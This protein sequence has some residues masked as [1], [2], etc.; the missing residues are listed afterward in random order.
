[1]TSKAL[2][3]TPFKARLQILDTHNGIQRDF[4]AALKGEALAELAGDNATKLPGLTVP[5]KA[6]PAAG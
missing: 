2:L 5:A 3:G 1:L 6:A 4:H